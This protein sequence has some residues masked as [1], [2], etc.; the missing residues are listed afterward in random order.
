MGI[1]RIGGEPTWERA[2]EAVNRAIEAALESLPGEARPLC[3][4]GE[5]P[6]GIGT[7]PEEDEPSRGTDMVLS[8]SGMPFARVQQPLSCA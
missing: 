7:G 3:E 2:G 5:E 6:S 8:C 4:P 1:W